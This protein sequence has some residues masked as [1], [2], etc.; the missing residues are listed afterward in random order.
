MGVYLSRHLQVLFATLGGMR[1]NLLTTLTTVS[2]IGISLLLPTLLYITLKSGTEIAQN[3]EGQPQF[4]IFLQA[5]LA[6]QEAQ[7]IFEELRLHPAVELAEFISPAQALEEFK[8]LSELDF[9][10]SFLGENPLPASVVVLPND[11][12][13]SSSQLQSLRD[14]LAKIEGIEDIRLDLEWTDRFNAL[15]SSISVGT[16]I[17]SALLLLALVL[18]VSTTIKLLIINRRDE[19]VITKLVGG[20]NRFVRRPFLY[21]GALYGFLGAVVTLIL[22][23][24]VGN[25]LQTPMQALAELYQRETLVYSVAWY[26]IVILLAASSSL[27][28]VAARISVARHLGEIK[29]K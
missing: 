8:M 6:D 4:S 17:L 26:E 24:V 27:G 28:W 3:W 19:I 15:L 23:L 13:H 9:E 16:Q 5:N 14:E 7:L 10:L 1:R 12:F 11:G 20:S 21:F 18:I 22:L 2:L 25:L 29:P